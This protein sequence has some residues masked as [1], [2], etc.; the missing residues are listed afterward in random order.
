MMWRI[1]LAAAAVAVLA[2]CII[3]PVD[4]GWYF[5]L[6]PVIKTRPHVV[7]ITGGLSYATD[8]RYEMFLYGGK[9]YWYTQNR[10]YSSNRYNGRWRK[11]RAL[12]EVFYNIPES[13]PKYHT[14]R[15]A[16]LER[17]QAQAKKLRD[18]PARPGQIPPPKRSVRPTPKSGTRPATPAVPGVRPAIPARPA[19]KPGAKRPVPRPG[20]KPPAPAVVPRPQETR[21]AAPAPPKRR[22]TPPKKADKDEKEKK[23]REA[24]RKRLEKE[25]KD[26]GRLRK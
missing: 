5:G 3:L 13:H 22:P 16:R 21:R 7:A 14:V 23:K 12:P 19:P 1:V 9:W 6:A 2:G 24:E 11:V 4:G 8:V 15:G 18:K 10:W 25:R 20:A 17:A 26:R